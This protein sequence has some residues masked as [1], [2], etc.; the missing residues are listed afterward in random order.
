MNCL[1]CRTL[2]LHNFFSLIKILEYTGFF[3]W[4]TFSNFGN[5]EPE[6]FLI[7]MLILRFDFNPLNA[8]VALI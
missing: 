5:H 1:F 7:V 4:Y 6:R 3:V 8:S 2:D